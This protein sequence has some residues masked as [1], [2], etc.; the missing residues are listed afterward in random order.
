MLVAWNER[1]VSGC[2]DHDRRSTAAAVD[3]RPPTA[4]STCQPSRSSVRA[5]RR[6]MVRRSPSG[7]AA[8]LASR[9]LV[10]V[11]G[12]ARGVDSAAHRGAL[13]GRRCHDRGARIRRG[14]DLSARSTRRSRRRSIVDGA[15][16]S[17]F[18]PGTPPQPWFFPAAQPDHQRPVA[19]GGRDRGG[20]EERVADHGAL[21]A[22]TGARRPGRARQRAER[23]QPRRPRA[24]YGTVQRLWSPR[25]ISSR[26]WVWPR[27]RPALC[28]TGAD[29]G[30]SPRRT[31]T[32]CSPVW[33]RAKP[34]DLDEIAERSGPQAVASLLPRLFE[35]ESAGAGAAG[36]RRPVHAD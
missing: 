30:Q 28:G 15:V 6:P 29:P 7:L 1:R 4:F 14:R 27:V 20:R 11:S 10:V 34:C 19:R 22:R 9:G 32:R 35:L 17:E 36:R 33:R 26:S 18:V 13:A 3:A 16:V 23:P 24:A 12:L 8:D 21:R 2:I 25:T 31:P 5:P